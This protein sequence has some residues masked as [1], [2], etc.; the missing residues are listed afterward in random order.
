MLTPQ[1]KDQITSVHLSNNTDMGWGYYFAQNEKPMDKSLDLT[2]FKNLQNIEA[3]WYLNS[4]LQEIKAPANTDHIFMQASCTPRLKRP[5]NIDVFLNDTKTSWDTWD[6]WYERDFPK[7]HEEA[8]KLFDERNCRNFRIHLG[9]LWKENDQSA[10]PGEITHLVETY[11]DLAVKAA[12]ALY[13]NTEEFEERDDFSDEL[14]L[15]ANHPSSIKGKTI[16]DVHPEV[17][18]NYY[19]MM[20]WKTDC[21]FSSNKEQIQFGI[22]HPDIIPLIEERCK[23]ILTEHPDAIDDIAHDLAVVG[24]ANPKFTDSVHNVLQQQEW[25]NLLKDMDEVIKSHG[26]KKDTELQKDKPEK[27]SDQK[28][29]V[30]LSKIKSR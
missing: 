22:D 27:A 3:H 21:G 26:T 14:S 2:S 7:N 30:I 10:Q 16:M 19:D 29:N 18:L 11:P 1:S 28:L 4:N 9:N 5:E 6:M 20:A 17:A 13:R 23:K 25:P 15:L 8:E 24:A 12:E